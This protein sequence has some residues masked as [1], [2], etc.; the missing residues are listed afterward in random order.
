MKGNL[1]SQT[2]VNVIWAP[3]M[4]PILGPK[5]GPF[6]PSQGP[7]GEALFGEIPCQAWVNPPDP[8]PGE[9]LQT[10]YLGPPGRPFLK[11]DLSSQTGVN[12]IWAPGM[13]PK[14]GPFWSPI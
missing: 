4:G 9:A 1:S 13:G 12:V 7:P 10:P 14:I 2:G 11:E 5:T 3:G 6:E 8:G